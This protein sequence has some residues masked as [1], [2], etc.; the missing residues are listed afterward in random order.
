VKTR[1]GLIFN[2]IAAALLAG[3]IALWVRSHR[4]CDALVWQRWHNDA[5]RTSARSA[6]S[7]PAAA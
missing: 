2:V 3:V 5:A 1:L 7:A 4:T 6:R